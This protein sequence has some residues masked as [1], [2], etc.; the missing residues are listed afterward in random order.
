[1]YMELAAIPNMINLKLHHCMD[2]APS[3]EKTI[4]IP[5]GKLDY[6]GEEGVPLSW[7]SCKS[8]ED[9]VDWYREQ[10]PFVNE[11]V[12]PYLVRKT[13]YPSQKDKKTPK[14]KKPRPSFT[15]RHGNFRVKFK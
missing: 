10:L 15:R 5:K 11:T 12:L 3:G 8:F 14:R 1:M 7:K 6:L 9:A 4:A 13:L 2:P